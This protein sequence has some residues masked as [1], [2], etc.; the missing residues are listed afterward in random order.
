M[1]DAFYRLILDIFI[2]IC[3]T[4]KTS[5]LQLPA[6]FK[7]SRMC[8]C[9]GKNFNSIEKVLIVNIR[10]ALTLTSIRRLVMTPGYLKG[11]V[12]CGRALDKRRC[13]SRGICMAFNACQHHQLPPLCQNLSRH[14]TAAED[15]K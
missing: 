5:L 4:G 9:E 11:A 3:T 2:P 13:D 7:I 15:A 14:L 8:F 1:F 12:A 6:I 10:V